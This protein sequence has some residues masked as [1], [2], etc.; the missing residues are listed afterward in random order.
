MVKLKY[1]LIPT[2]FTI[3]ITM[4]Q[5][6]ESTT[7]TESDPSFVEQHKIF[8]VNWFHIPRKKLLIM[9]YIKWLIPL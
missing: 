9:I 1:A 3:L 8:G 4:L 7:T 5:I 6:H 2:F